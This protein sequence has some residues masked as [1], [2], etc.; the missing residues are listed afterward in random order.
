[1][2]TERL[3]R[4]VSPA[5]I[6]RQIPPGRG[7]PGRRSGKPPARGPP[8]A[9]AARLGNAVSVARSECATAGPSRRRSPPRAWPQK[10]RK[11]KQAMQQHRLFQTPDSRS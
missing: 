7:F 9:Q 1:M 5:A 10:G 2:G 6:H 8:S 11:R 4:R 3:D